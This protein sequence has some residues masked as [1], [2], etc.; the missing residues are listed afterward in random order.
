IEEVILPEDNR[1][2]IAEIPPEIKKAIRFKYFSAAIEAIK[3]ALD[4][5]AVCGGAAANAAAGRKRK[6][7]G[8]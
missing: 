5:P 2:D 7:P 8:R 1:K 6:R 4:R 3:Y